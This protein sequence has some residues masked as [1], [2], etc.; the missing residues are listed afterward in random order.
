MNIVSTHPSD[1]RMTNALKAALSGI[2]APGWAVVCGDRREMAVEALRLHYEGVK[3]VHVQGGDTPHGTDG[4]P[5]HRT[6][7]AIS[8]LARLHFVANEDC[9]ANLAAIGITGGVFVTGNPGLDWI[10]E[11][12]SRSPNR[13]R[14]RRAGVMIHPHPHDWRQSLRWLSAA[15]DRAPSDA[16][17]FAPNND[18]GGKLRKVA[19]EFCKLMDPLSGRDFVSW[20]AATELFVTNSSAGILEAPILGTPVELVGDRQAGRSTKPHH[21]PEGKACEMVADLVREYC[22]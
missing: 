14:N 22:K 11:M 5:D 13:E 18:D 9:K 17:V 10:V 3:L 8:M 4:H 21:H 19:A 12:A 20:L 2:D 1:H 7:D 16:L 6:R 15:L